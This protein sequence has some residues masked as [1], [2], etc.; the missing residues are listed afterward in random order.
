MLNRKLLEVVSRLSETEQKRLRL[1][2]QA[3]YFNDGYN[4]GKIVQL[5]DY[6]LKNGA[7]EN[8]PALEKERVAAIF[9]PDKAFSEKGKGP[10]DSLASDLFRLVRAF[11]HQAEWEKTDSEARE[12]LTLARFYRKNGLEERFKPTLQAIQKAQDNNPLR[13]AN[14]YFTQFQVEEEVANFKSIYSSNEDDFNLFAVHQNLDTFFTI[15]KLEALCSSAFQSKTSAVNSLPD[16]ALTRVML[17]LVENQSFKDIPIT[18]AYQ[19]AYQ[20]IQNP[21]RE[22]A[23]QELEESLE[24]HA[25]T[26]PAE[27]YRDLQALYRALWAWRYRREG[28]PD[29]GIRLFRLYAEHLKR[30]Y[31]YIDGKILTDAMRAITVFGLWAKEFDWVRRFL[32]EHPPERLYGTRFPVEFY[33]LN[34]AEYHFALRNFEESVRFLTYQSFENATYSIWADLLLVKIYYETQDELLETRMKALDQKIRRSG[35]SQENK[36]LY[37]SFLQKLAKIIKYGWEKG[38]PKLAK[39]REEIQTTPNIASREWLLE[40]LDQD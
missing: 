30:G 34:F 21:D 1:Y 29:F 33:N 18:R 12:W 28:G 4:A 24:Q 3:T 35:I 26:V 6:V 27:K 37:L 31:F 10:I 9:F 13:D 5:Y 20:L 2:L 19:L 15:C 8:E 22:G 17:E 32:E 39:L 40:K 25:S 11:L 7:D 14:Y 38:S 36:V 23:L 16:S